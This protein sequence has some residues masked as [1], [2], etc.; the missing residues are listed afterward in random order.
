VRKLVV[1]NFRSIGGAIEL[2][3][4]SE[5]VLIHGP[6]GAGK[7]SVLSALELALTGNARSLG[8]EPSADLS[9]L[10][11][12]GQPMGRVAV[13]LTDGRTGERQL[14]RS[15]GSRGA[16][17]LGE[18]DSD[19]YRE[20]CFLP[21][22]YLGRLLEMYTDSSGSDGGPLIEFVKQICGV[23]EFESLEIGVK[24]SADERLARR[25]SAAWRAAHSV[26]QQHL[27][28]IERLAQ[29]VDAAKERIASILAELA[30]YP[31]AR[32][33]ESVDAEIAAIQEELRVAEA[34]R[35][36]VDSAKALAVDADSTLLD[37]ESDL[38]IR[39]AEANAMFT[40]EWNRV[41]PMV[42]KAS[43]RVPELLQTDPFDLSARVDA[44]VSEQQEIAAAARAAVAEFKLA[45]V[46]KVASEGRI[47]SLTEQERVLAQRIGALVID[48]DGQG[49]LLALSALLNHVNGEVCPLCD[50]EFLGDI[51]LRT[52]IEQKLTAL[53]DSARMLEQLTQEVGS[54][55]ERLRSEIAAVSL[56]DARLAALAGGEG[57]ESRAAE[58]ETTAGLLSNLS[59][60]VKP[61]SDL[62][63]VSASLEA[64]LERN[65]RRTLLIAEAA[66][67]IAEMGLSVSSEASI[68]FDEI[69]SL[70]SRSIDDK[71]GTLYARLHSMES[72]L[73][74]HQ[75]LDNA[76]RD[77]AD[78][79]SERR[80]VS[81]ERRKLRSSIVE[82]GKRKS[83][84]LYMLKRSRQLRSEIV[85]QV[86]THTL[87]DAWTGIF[88]RLAPSEA[89][90]PVF[91]FESTSTGLDVRLSTLT[92]SGQQGGDP[93]S[94]LSYGN[95]NSAALSLFLALHFSIE[96]SLPVLA[97]DDPVQS[98]DEV[99]VANFAAMGR[100]IARG[101]QARQLL[102]TTH[103]RGLFDYLTLEFFPSS[104]G[105]RLTTVVL[106]SQESDPQVLHHRYDGDSALERLG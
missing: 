80:V 39:A 89:F 30:V 12:L 76:R 36:R 21:Q 56:A 60:N 6:N 27:R 38:H 23:D 28:T 22:T 71:V 69:A 98:M 79:E 97:I 48:G 106:T 34:N 14:S 58:A 53:T 54:I 57:L 83:N 37:Q 91:K 17:A 7:T 65:R 25:D 94:T 90:L 4:D 102:M 85:E 101:R 2:D 32:S 86:F 100:E 78:A 24:S 40:E 49:L 75:E 81:R 70:A 50:Q 9:A 72:A 62:A 64:A 8:Y 16:A 67:V 105:E 95:L 87:A 77:L 55:K 26:D 61:A 96:T 82:A 68:T 31:A 10:I 104:H 52:H 88:G 46:A 42:E 29:R 44:I 73:Q 51:P 13:E 15:N 11:H 1:E 93:G 47:Q 84:A 103:D 41:L 3:L 59:K 45:Q 18:S 63:A 19:F 35:S 99:H 43:S 33:T 66:R 20:R 92:T 5:I 74:M